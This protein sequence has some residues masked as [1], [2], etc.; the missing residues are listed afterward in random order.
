VTDTLQTKVAFHRIWKIDLNAH[1][2]AEEVCTIANKDHLTRL[3]RGMD[4]W[5]TWRHE[6]PEITPDLRAAHLTGADL[7]GAHLSG[8]HLTGATLTGAHLSKASISLMIFAECDQN[9]W[10]AG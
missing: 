9:L 5:N 8:A 4:A 2:Q 7:T 1:S 10:T 3:Q 6:T